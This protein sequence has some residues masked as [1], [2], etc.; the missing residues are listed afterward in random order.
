MR[1]M[2]ESAAV[3]D[4]M[5]FAA[6]VVLFVMLGQAHSF[7]AA[8][9]SIAVLPL[10]A[11]DT[12]LPY[13]LLPSAQELASM[14]AQLRAGLQSHG[15][16]L[17]P[18]AATSAALSAGGFDQTKPERACA[19]ISCA[20]AIGRKLHAGRVVFGAVTREMAV[21]WSTEYSV[22]DVRTGKMLQHITLG[23]K[24]DVQAME[25]GERYAGGCLARVM[26]NQPPCPP[27][28]GW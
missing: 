20:L 25:I 10:A 21:V 22:A 9:P 15:I 2:V 14:T 26:R 18:A 16:A 1:F 28:R 19:S 23:Y 13:G 24:G 27:D 11:A 6:L 7:A 3:R 8:Q 5:K 12:G 17:V 4:T